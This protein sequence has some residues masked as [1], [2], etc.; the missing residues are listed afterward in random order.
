MLQWPA[1]E[2]RQIEELFAANIMVFFSLHDLRPSIVPFLNSF[3][4]TVEN[5]VSHPANIM[6]LK[7][8]DFVQE[9]LDIMLKAV[10]ITPASA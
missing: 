10:I 4:L 9:E 2:S 7:H 3:E 6:E 8:S 5:S 1:E